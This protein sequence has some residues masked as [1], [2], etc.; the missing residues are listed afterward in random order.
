M[1][2]ATTI[3]MLLLFIMSIN[4]FG[5]LT[6]QDAAKGMS[7]GIN[8]GNTMDP[9]SGEGTWG[10]PAVK[11]RAFS[12]YKNAGFT[13]IRIPITWD[14]YVLKTSP[15]TI[16][17]TWLDRVDTVVKWGLEQKLIIIINMHHEHW[18][19]KESANYTPGNIARFDSI[20]SQIATRF[21]NH[22]DSLLF[23]MIN[24]PEG[25]SA[26]QVNELNKRTL[27]TIRKTNPTR[28]VLFSGHSWSN[29]EH[30]IAAEIPD[31][32]DKY[33]MGYY[34]SYDPYPFGLEGP[35]SYGSDA[36]IR[37]SRNKFES[38]KKWSDE[39]GIPVILGE[40]A[41]NEKC[42]YNSRM[43]AY[44]TIM[45]L[46]LEYGIPA[47]VWDDG[48]W[49]AMYNRATGT[50]NEIKD[51][52]IH[53]YKES[54]NKITINQYKDTL[55]QVRWKN[56]TGDIDSLTLERRIGTSNFAFYKKIGATDSIFTD[57]NIKTGSTYYYRLKFNLKDSIDVLSY[58]VRMVNAKPVQKNYLDKELKIPGTVEAE[59]FDEGMAGE[60]YF[61]NDAENK[62]DIYR[63]SSGVDIAKSGTSVYYLT[64]LEK[65]EWQEY[66]LNVSKSG[67][68]KLTA[69]MAAESDG[70]E[71][72]LSFNDELKSTFSISSTG[73]TTTFAQFIDTLNLEQGISI[74][75]ASIS[76]P[77]FN[78]NKYVFSLILATSINDLTQKISVY[79][80][81]AGE[82]I[83]L[84]GIVNDV[85]IK[86]YN[87][88]GALVKVTKLSKGNSV[89]I[90][91]LEDGLYFLQF[92]NANKIFTEKFI[93]STKK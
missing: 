55:I 9:P 63:F 75:R 1:K 80:N 90:S 77:G 88:N 79:P 73:S 68:Y 76:K 84:Y 69:Y 85:N 59:N 48:G 44:A 50:F 40:F 56:R 74:M 78:I 61:D 66:T 43:C 65:D 58:P 72:K 83:I 89:D 38:V 31:V 45:E 54:P 8:I 19:K 46:S 42:E 82:K 6:P 49:F 81:P 29:S 13:A 70:G 86:I 67:I 47:F 4:T 11:K 3:F 91:T 23:E 52:L 7:R 34:H 36:D 14:K 37:A 16:N 22:S 12:D 24:E 53:T 64:S 62:G 35:G 93:K 26:T 92:N 30:L 2:K 21:R 60:S 28:I 32:N 5:Q 18:L 33:L 51:I 10:N 20:W 39:K 27:A 41:Y 87:N 17:K 15:Y 57:T 71:L 25:L